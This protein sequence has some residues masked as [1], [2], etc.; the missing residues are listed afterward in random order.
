MPWWSS[1]TP[2]PAPEAVRLWL[3]AKGSQRAIL[4]TDYLEAAGMPDGTYK[5]GQTVIHVKGATC[6]TE[7]GVLAGSVISLDRAVR[8]CNR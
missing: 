5:L 3:K 8:T 7:D 2:L 6:T 4:I 1:T